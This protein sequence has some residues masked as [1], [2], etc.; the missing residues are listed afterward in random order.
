MDII[1][2][3]YYNQGTYIEF[4]KDTSISYVIIGGGWINSSI[5]SSG[6]GVITYSI[7]GGGSSSGGK[8]NNAG[9]LG[10]NGGGGASNN[11][12]GVMVL[13]WFGGKSN[14]NH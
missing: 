8:V 10:T 13:L 5:Y 12:Y 11:N 3:F 14:S 6:S 4:L 7:Y 2:S 9:S 1:I